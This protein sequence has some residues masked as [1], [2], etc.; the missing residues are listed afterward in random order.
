MVPVLAPSAPAP[1]GSVDTLARFGQ[2]LA[3]PLRCRILLALRQAPAYPAELA[4]QLGVS[5]TRLSNHLT[6]LRGC[7]LV[8]ATP[9]GRRSRYQLA[10]PRLAHALDDLLQVVAAVADGDAGRG[11]PELVP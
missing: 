10:D 1:Q 7:G 11:C 9:Q 5:R 6:C 8:T 3:D 2:A 4:E